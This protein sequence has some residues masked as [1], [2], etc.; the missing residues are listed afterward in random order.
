VNQRIKMVGAAPDSIGAATPMVR[1]WVE[2]A[3][4]AAAATLRMNGFRE[5][6]EH[7]TTQVARSSTAFHQVDLRE[8]QEV[9]KAASMDAATL[10]ASVMA[11][12]MAPWAPQPMHLAVDCSP[13]ILVVQEA[14][15]ALRLRLRL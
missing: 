10:A 9:V 8:Q 4:G 11:W 14:A 1:G 12:V 5:I 7:P 13:D 3:T 2:L 6:A 15:P